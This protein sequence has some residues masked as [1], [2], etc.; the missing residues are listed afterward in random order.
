VGNAT[1]AAS[2]RERSSLARG[3]HSW[4]HAPRP[5]QAWRNG[6]VHA[7]ELPQLRLA[8][9]RGAFLVLLVC[10]FYEATSFSTCSI[11]SFPFYETT[12]AQH[13]SGGRC[14]GIWDAWSFLFSRRRQW[15]AS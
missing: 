15:G 9:Q 2:S 8:P 13:A 3:W 11:P 14:G 12:L 7:V 6:A 4:G 10:A 5:Q 1:S